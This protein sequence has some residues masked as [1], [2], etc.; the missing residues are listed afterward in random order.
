M[1]DRDEERILMQAIKVLQGRLNHVRF[2]QTSELE[3]RAR[4]IRHPMPST[5]N[6]PDPNLGRVPVQSSPH[7]V[8]LNSVSDRGISSNSSGQKT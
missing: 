6:C 5:A 8:A 4:Q 2:F 1:H 3:E 7:V